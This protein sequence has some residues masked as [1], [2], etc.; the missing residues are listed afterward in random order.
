MLCVPRCP[1]DGRESG[2][3]RKW[4]SGEGKRTD[5][6]DGQEKKRDGDERKENK[7][8]GKGERRGKKTGNW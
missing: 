5:D 3:E 4:E 2:G 1:D 7:K 8:E 6:K